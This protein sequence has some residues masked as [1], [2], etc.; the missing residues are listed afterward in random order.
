MIII[1]VK[2]DEFK[3]HVYNEITTW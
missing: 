3:E 2:V 1:K